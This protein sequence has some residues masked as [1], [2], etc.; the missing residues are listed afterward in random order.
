M[1]KKNPVQHISEVQPDYAVIVTAYEQTDNLPA[2]VNS[3]L[4]MNYS[5]FLVYVVADKC[6]I[7]NF[8]FTD[9]RVILLKPE[10]TLGSNTRSHF[11]A[12]TRFKKE[13]D[14]LTI[15]DSDN[16]VDKDYLLKLNTFFNRGFSAVQ[17]IRKAKNLDT[18]YACLDA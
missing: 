10:E 15:I 5:N 12:I 7:S 13:H 9:E 3:L 18:T 11:Y 4:Q 14:Y 8:Y 6:D 16:L 1:R 17:G 2:V